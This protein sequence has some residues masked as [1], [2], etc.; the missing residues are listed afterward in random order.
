LSADAR[1]LFDGGG[2]SI[3]LELDPSRTRPY[4]A[5]IAL[6][7]EHDLATSTDIRIALAPLHGD[8]LVD[9]SE[10]EFID[11]AVIG[12]L[13]EKFEDLRREGHRLELLVPLDRVNV[14]RSVGVIGLGTLMTLH[15]AMPTEAARAPGDGMTNG[16]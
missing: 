4:A 3:R 7:G 10:C 1:Q 5:V 9:L 13:L 16:E 15:E 6:C 8:V 2:E 12:A 14:R 11:S